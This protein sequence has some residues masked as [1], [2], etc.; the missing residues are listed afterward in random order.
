MYVVLYFVFVSFAFLLFSRMIYEQICIFNRSFYSERL[1]QKFWS[2][3]PVFD[4]W[5]YGFQ[6]LGLLPS[7]KR[8]NVSYGRKT[9]RVTA[10]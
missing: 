8:K 4:F 5:V 3:F 2:S 1:E 10:D 6:G 9:H 7:K